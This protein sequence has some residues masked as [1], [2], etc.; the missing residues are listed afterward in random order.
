MLMFPLN[1]VTLALKFIFHRLYLARQLKF[2]LALGLC[3]PRLSLTD[4]LFKIVNA[5]SEV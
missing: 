2:I 5:S 4:H 3:Y 1:Q